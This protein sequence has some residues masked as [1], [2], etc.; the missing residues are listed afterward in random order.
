[1]N[2]SQCLRHPRARIYYEDT[3]AAGVVYYANY[4]EVFR[5]AAPNGCVW[6]ATISP[7]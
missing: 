2:K 7:P 3:D 1:M 6:S 4:L 5:A